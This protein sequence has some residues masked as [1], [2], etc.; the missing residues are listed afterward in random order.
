MDKQELERRTRQFAV[1]VIAF[2]NGFGSSAAGR[3]IGNQLLKSGT[4]IGANY[5]E[6]NRAVSR[7]DFVHKITIAEKEASETAYWLEICAETS[8]G[9]GDV[10][11]KLSTEAGE[12]LAIFTSIGR[13]VRVNDRK[14]DQGKQPRMSEHVSPGYPSE[15]LDVH[16]SDLMPE[17]MRAENDD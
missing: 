8:L 5:R 7:K 4:S 13:S 15:D 17:W 3:V 9:K 6:A 2:V 10:C 1:E 16:F 12:L 14:S 11:R